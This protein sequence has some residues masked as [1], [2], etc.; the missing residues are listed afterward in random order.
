MNWVFRPTSNN[1]I[2]QST[3]SDGKVI[4]SFKTRLNFSGEEGENVVIMGSKE[5]GSYFEYTSQILSVENKILDD[6]KLKIFTVTLSQ[7]ELIKTPN[8][9]DDL[10]Y[11]LHKVY[12]YDRPYIH[13]NRVYSRLTKDDFEVIANGK[14]FVARTAFGK[15]VNALHQ[16]HRI[17]FVQMLI[18]R[19]PS[20]YFTSRK[21]DEVFD[22]LKEYI[23]TRIL[24]FTEF[25]SGAWNNFQKIN[26]DS[27]NQIAFAESSESRRDLISQQIDSI[28]K[29]N[30]LN[31]QNK[32]YLRLESVEIEFR[33]TERVFIRKF[34]KKPLPISM[35]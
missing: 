1:S 30:E 16:K 9:L 25:L 8:K 31:A 2:S 32:F 21:Y 23:E 27:N 22:L 7:P 12:N 20:I 35:K 18:E 5:E 3:A 33:D 15:L 17:A 10:L 34:S 13:F 14:L 24:I 28:N 29:M 6:Q 4:F 11:S 19:N 26:P